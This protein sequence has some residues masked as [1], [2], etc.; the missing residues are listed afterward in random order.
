MMPMMPLMAGIGSTGGLQIN[1]ALF[2]NPM[3]A[4]LP[5]NFCHQMGIR[6]LAG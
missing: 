4:P 2:G 3:V 6:A 1:D 5:M